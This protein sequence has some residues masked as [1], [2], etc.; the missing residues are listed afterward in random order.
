MIT[1]RH[2]Q[3]NDFPAVLEVLNFSH[4]K[5]EF[6]ES[7]L[8]EKLN[9]CKEDASELYS[10][11]SDSVLCGFVMTVIR[12]LP[13]GPTAFIKL[14]GVLP[15]FQNRGIGKKLLSY[16]ENFATEHSCKTIR[17]YDVPK[18]YF[19]PGIDPFYTKTVVFAERNGFIRNGDTSNL[20]SDLSQNWD[21]EQEESDLKKIDCFCKRATDED[22]P[23]LLAW[24]LREFPLWEFELV[25]ALNQN[26]SAVHL[27]Y[28]QNELIAFAAH[29]SN[30]SSLAWFGPMGTSIKSRGKGVG[31]VL[32]KRCLQDL[33]NL[34]FKKAVIPWV[35]PIPF[36]SKFANA[37]VSRVFW[38]YEKHM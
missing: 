13:T 29:S 24:I 10:A 20:E 38:R 3:E 16:G 25:Q 27:A 6:S 17:F 5:D 2:Y 31:A 34:G 4:P 37:H 11:F 19:M 7:L 32:L 21:T 14:I 23:E 1:Y 30:N 28:F 36:Y 22:Y 12:Q 18:N 33:K 15:E 35:G 26:P 8:R 9:D